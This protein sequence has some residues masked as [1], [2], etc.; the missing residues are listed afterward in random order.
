MCDNT[1]TKRGVWIIYYGGWEEGRITK[2]Y[3][4]CWNTG[5]EVPGGQTWEGSKGINRSCWEKRDVM[6]VS[7]KEW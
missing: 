6:S 3:I 7:P 4:R 5:P 2:S 1:P